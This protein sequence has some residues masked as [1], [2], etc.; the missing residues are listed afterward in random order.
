MT[1]T[2]ALFVLAALNSDSRFYGPTNEAMA[3]IYSQNS[4]GSFGNTQST[5]LALKVHSLG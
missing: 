1:E 2:T 4:G 3:F 5:I